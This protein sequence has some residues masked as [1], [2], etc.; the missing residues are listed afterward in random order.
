V[1]EAI[2]RADVPLRFVWGP[3]DPVS[4]AHMLAE[5]RMRRPDAVVAELAGV[6]HYP[7]TR[8]PRRRRARAERAGP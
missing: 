2:A 5:L 7:Q 8:G 4:G 3:L 6:G 1:E